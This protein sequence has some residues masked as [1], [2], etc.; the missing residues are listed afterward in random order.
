MQGL[1]SKEIKFKV[2][3]ESIVIVRMVVENLGFK[4]SWDEHVELNKLPSQG[5]EIFSAP[6]NRIRIW[7][8][9][10]RYILNQ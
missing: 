4:K 6:K 10:T 1:N 3:N 8:N 7:V 2:K 9:L 5:H